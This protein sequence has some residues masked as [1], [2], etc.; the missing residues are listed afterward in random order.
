MNR[1]TAFFLGLV[2]AVVSLGAVNYA[3]AAGNSTIKACANKKTGA[4]RYIKKGSCK[5][6]ESVLLWNQQGLQ[7]IPGSSA[8][9]NG[10][11]Q[12]HVVDS[13]GRDFGI[14][15]IASSTG[16]TVF[17]DGGVWSFSSSPT[18][19]I[20][21]DGSLENSSRIFWDSTCT[22]PIFKTAAGSN[23]TPS[24]RAYWQWSNGSRTYYKPN[25]YPFSGSSLSTFYTLAYTDTCKL[26]SFIDSNYGTSFT[27]G[28]KSPSNFYTSVVQVN[29]PPYLAPFSLVLK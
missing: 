4:M 3:N 16:A 12:I 17:Y 24:T 28:V 10:P 11:Q 21:G 27:T 5:N 22:Q 7:G 6:T 1:L 13:A 20:S 25:G 19:N 29:P 15:L 9:A 18:L 14:P 2:F 8:S 23:A 26:S